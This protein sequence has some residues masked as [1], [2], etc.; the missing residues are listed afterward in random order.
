MTSS[1]VVSHIVGKSECC[2]MSSR[3]FSSC[4]CMQLYLYAAAPTLFV[5][6]EFAPKL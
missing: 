2:C 1:E 4:G 5:S 6:M 3:G